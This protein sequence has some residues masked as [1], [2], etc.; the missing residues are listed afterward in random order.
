LG[1]TRRAGGLEG[2][3]TKE[4][5]SVGVSVNSKE[6][7]FVDGD[8]IIQSQIDLNIDVQ[9]LISNEDADS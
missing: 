7:A 4:F 1:G 3:L 2:R 5:I 9:G 6:D 8:R